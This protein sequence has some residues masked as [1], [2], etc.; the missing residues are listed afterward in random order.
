MNTE[1]YNIVTCE[2]RLKLLKYC[3]RYIISNK[4]NRHITKEFTTDGPVTGKEWL[5]TMCP[6]VQVPFSPE[7]WDRSIYRKFL[8][9]FLI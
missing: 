3:F 1:T 9:F 6:T 5:F 7:E 8:G 4:F 2:I